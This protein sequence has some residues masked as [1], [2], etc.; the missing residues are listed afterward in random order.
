MTSNPIPR[1]NV[2][3]KKEMKYFQNNLI[4]IPKAIQFQ[5]AIQ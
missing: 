3:M 5:L 1:Y 2:V 4:Q